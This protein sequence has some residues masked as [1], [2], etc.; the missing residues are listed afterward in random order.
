MF[1]RF[2]TPART[3]VVSARDRARALD[4]RTITTAHVLLALVEGEAGGTLREHGVTADAVR[5]QLTELTGADPGAAHDDAAVLAA[6]GIDMARIREAVEA[7]FGPGA[8]DR[9]LTPRDGGRRGLLGRLRL[10]RGGGGAD[11][12]A[13]PRDE[14]AAM[15]LPGGSSTGHLPFSPAAKKALELSLREAMRLGD[16]WI[17]PEHLTLGLIRSGD[18]AAAVVLD[19]LGV[20]L[21]AIRHEVEQQRRRPA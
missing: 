13:L 15:R 19:R 8:L 20:D 21:G 3:A 16:G 12:S 7:N 6:L 18:G 9:P 10:L 1:E 17:G 2:T 11:R 14:V 5:A 4:H